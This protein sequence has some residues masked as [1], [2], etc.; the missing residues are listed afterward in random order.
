MCASLKIAKR[1]SLK[2]SHYTE[3]VTMSISCIEVI[4]SQCKVLKTSY[5]TLEIYNV[6]FIILIAFTKNEVPWSTFCCCSIIPK[7][8]LV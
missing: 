7:V 8:G 6:N 4:T 2:Y 3:K 1:V 5:H